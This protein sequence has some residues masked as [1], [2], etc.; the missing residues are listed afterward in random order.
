MMPNDAP[1][2]LY[3]VLTGKL[4][5]MKKRPYAQA[6]YIDPHGRCQAKEKCGNDI[7]T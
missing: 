6:N 3:G 4:G 7:Q 2:I 5:W 1:E